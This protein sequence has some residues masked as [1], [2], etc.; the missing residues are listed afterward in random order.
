MDSVKEKKTTKIWSFKRWKKDHSWLEYD[1][2]MKM[3]CK[4]CTAQRGK[5]EI[6]PSYIT[7]RLSKEVLI[8]NRRH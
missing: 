4:I 7:L 2:E 5:K 8:K 1:K 3:I 6:I